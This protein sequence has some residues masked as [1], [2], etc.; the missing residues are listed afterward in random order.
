MKE[1]DYK[2]KTK[3]DY[4]NKKTKFGFIGMNEE[5]AKAHNIPWKHKKHPEETIEIYKHMP[6]DF[7]TTTEHHE[8]IERYLMKSKH[9]KYHEAHANALRFENLNIP[10]PTKNIKQKLKEEHFK[11]K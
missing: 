2:M 3:I 7:R 11:I 9:E 6:K 4:I 5:A 8:E 10:F 1:V